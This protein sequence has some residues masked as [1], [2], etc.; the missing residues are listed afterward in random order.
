MRCLSCDYNLSHLTEHRCPE[1][2]RAFDPN[3]PATFQRPT[4][5]T[6]RQRWK[7]R[8]GESV[9]AICIVYP[10]FLLLKHAVQGGPPEFAVTAII[11]FLAILS[12]LLLYAAFDWIAGWF[13]KTR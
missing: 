1:C 8:L 12:T 7:K 13:K 11:V 2:G 4:T 6:M 9:I 3:D 5:T 10:L